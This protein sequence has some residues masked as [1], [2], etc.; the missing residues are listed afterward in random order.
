MD[1]T[2]IDRLFREKADN[3][4][5]TPS[6]DAWKVIDNQIHPKREHWKQYLKV[7][8]LLGVVLSTVLILLKVDQE[9]TATS[10][11][12]RTEIDHPQNVREAIISI[13][14][15]QKEI[16]ESTDAVSEAT[17]EPE[18]TIEPVQRETQF[19][20]LQNV[21]RKKIMPEFTQP[22]IPGIYQL[23]PAESKIQIKYY[24]YATPV[25]DEASKGKIGRLFE[26]A[27][28]TSPA[29]MLAKVREAKDDFIN[30]KLNLD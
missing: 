26:Y 2:K 27:Q 30:S 11:A 24:A 12:A 22:D 29:E 5:P 16:T 28:N 20:T 19:I 10:I 8:A 9:E 6:A 14:E 23:K 17:T 15:K 25:E 21:Q 7:A 18:L 4:Q 3:Y 13:P 1:Q